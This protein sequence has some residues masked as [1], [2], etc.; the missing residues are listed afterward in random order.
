MMY[1]PESKIALA[2]QVNTSVPRA[3]GKPLSR[4]LVELA[5]TIIKP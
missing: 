1:F 4:L 3:T 2:V 5:E